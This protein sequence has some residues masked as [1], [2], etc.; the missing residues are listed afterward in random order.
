VSYNA[1]DNKWQV[2]NS[3]VAGYYNYNNG[4]NGLTTAILA[5]AGGGQASATPLTTKFNVIGT[6]ISPEDSVILPHALVGMSIIVYNFGGNTAAVFPFSGDLIGALG[7]NASIDIANGSC[8][9]FTSEQNGRWAY[10]YNAVTGI[11]APTPLSQ[12]SVSTLGPNGIHYSTYIL[13]ALAVN[14]SITN[15]STPMGSGQSISMLI[16]DNGT[17]RTLT[18]GSAYKPLGTA[19]PTATVA[20]AQMFLEFR[21]EASTGFWFLIN[22]THA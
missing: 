20:G 2:I 12:T 4:F 8:M 19:L 21:Y 1:T 17:S 7:T 18:W 22:Y 5:F 14:L 15:P 16:K 3:N 13:T 11:P 6:V 10:T 9:V